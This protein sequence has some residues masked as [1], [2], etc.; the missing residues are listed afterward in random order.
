MLRWGLL[1]GWIVVL[2]ANAWMLQSGLSHPFDGN[3]LNLARV[4]VP[5]CGLCLSL[6]GLCWVAGPKWPNGPFS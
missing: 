5:F 2:V 3:I 6:Y 4:V 1:L